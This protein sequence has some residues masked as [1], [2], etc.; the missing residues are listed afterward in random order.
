[1]RVAREEMRWQQ[2]KKARINKLSRISAA[3]IGGMR[4]DRRRKLARCF[5][6]SGMEVLDQAR[7][8]ERA[9]ARSSADKLKR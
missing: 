8:S 6:A 1:M 3:D 9:G 7:A 2:L 4:P 5:R